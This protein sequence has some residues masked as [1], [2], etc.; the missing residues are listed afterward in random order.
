M[1]N[2]LRRSSSASRVSFSWCAT[3]VSHSFTFLLRVNEPFCLSA[4]RSTSCGSKPPERALERR[5]HAGHERDLVHAQI[6]AGVAHRLHRRQEGAREALALVEEIAQ[7]IARIGHQLE[8]IVVARAT[9]VRSSA[10]ISFLSSLRARRSPISP[11]THARTMAPLSR[12]KVSASA[13]EICRC[14]SPAPSRNAAAAD[15]AAA[16]ETGAGAGARGG[17]GS[18]GIASGSRKLGRRHLLHR[19]NRLGG[20]APDETRERVEAIERVGRLRRRLGLRR[21]LCAAP[22]G[23]R[24]RCKRRSAAARGRCSTRPRPGASACRRAAGRSAWRARVRGSGRATPRRRRRI[25]D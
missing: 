17:A 11:S 12:R 9:M 24:V 5:A 16:P 3:N 21:R 14:A 1:P 19:R 22:R 25:A 2:T 20:L 18:S 8:R 15:V 6:V 13:S 10:R 4:S 7:R 23:S